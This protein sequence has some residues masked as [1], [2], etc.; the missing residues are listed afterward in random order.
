L[1][2]L[3]DV[4]T[5]R[6]GRKKYYKSTY[7]SRGR[8]RTG[9]EPE[10]LRHPAG[11]SHSLHPTRDGPM[12]RSLRGPR[13]RAGSLGVCGG[14]QSEPALAPVDGERP[15]AGRGRKSVRCQDHQRG[16]NRQ[17]A[18]GDQGHGFSAVDVFA[19]CSGQCGI[20]RPAARVEIGFGINRFSRPACPQRCPNRR[21]YGDRRHAGDSAGVNMDRLVFLH[22]GNPS[23]W[24]APLP[25]TPPSLRLYCPER[26][27]GDGKWSRPALEN[28]PPV[29]SFVCLFT[30]RDSAPP[31]CQVRLDTGSRMSS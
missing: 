7:R 24:P 21:R 31:R 26:Q 28:L 29:R 6:R 2:R 12:T 3:G 30:G 4:G 18:A 11:R 20:D 8:S 13:E 10:G 14:V 23:P 16:G 22:I 1:C 19:H 27:G 15:V 25:A 9:S 5:D 17:V